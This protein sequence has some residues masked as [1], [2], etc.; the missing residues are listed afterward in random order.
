MN[1]TFLNKLNYFLLEK[2]NCEYLNKNN[3]NII[4][5]SLLGLSLVIP[6]Y[7]YICRSDYKSN[8]ESDYKPNQ[9]INYKPNQESDYKS[10]QESD[11]K[12]NQESD[13]KSNQES[14][15]ENKKIK[16]N[17]VIKIIDNNGLKKL[18]SDDSDE[19]KKYINIMSIESMDEFNLIDSDDF[20]N[21]ESDDFEGIFPYNN[22]DNKDVKDVKNKEKKLNPNHT[23]CVKAQDPVEKQMTEDTKNKNQVD[24]KECPITIKRME[25]KTECELNY[26]N[27]NPDQQIIKLICD[28]NYGNRI[29]WKSEK[30][31]NDIISNTSNKDINIIIETQGGSFASSHCRRRWRNRS[32]ARPGYWRSC[33]WQR[34]P[35]RLRRGTGG[36]S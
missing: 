31:F 4:T 3:K 10:N 6:I 8:Q 24:Q 13:Y 35:R 26:L 25:S 28:D 33:R 16:W 9:Q 34:R 19:Y 11:Y 32:P 5:L 18:E 12:P 36:W 23:S 15:N 1:F 29:C 17:E 7:L 20:V 22:I 2:F 30:I 21:L 14:D 27:E